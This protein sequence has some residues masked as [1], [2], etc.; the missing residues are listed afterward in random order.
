M[1]LS[2]LR[3][4]AIVVVATVVVIAVVMATVAGRMFAML[5]HLELSLLAVFRWF[6]I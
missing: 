3:T 6:P 5:G 1:G 4:R 2:G